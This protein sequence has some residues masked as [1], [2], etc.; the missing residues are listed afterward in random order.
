MQFMKGCCPMLVFAI[1]VVATWLVKGEYTPKLIRFPGTE[2]AFSPV[3]RFPC[4]MENWFFTMEKIG[5]KLW[6][7]LEGK[8]RFQCQPKR[9]L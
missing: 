9:H 1:V 6:S 2:N 4:W 8:V 7:F 5:L 3:E